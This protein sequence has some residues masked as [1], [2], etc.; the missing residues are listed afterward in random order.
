LPHHAFRP[1]GLIG[2]NLA[3]RRRVIRSSTTRGLGA[4]GG[5]LRESRAAI[6]KEGDLAKGSHNRRDA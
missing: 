6:R 1:V 5:A 4:G 2:V 3:E